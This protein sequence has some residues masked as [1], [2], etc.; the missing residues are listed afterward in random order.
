[1]VFYCIFRIERE[2]SEC[3]P[4]GAGAGPSRPEPE[5][6]GAGRTE[7]AGDGAEPAGA[8]AEPEPEPSRPEPEPSRSRAG[9]SQ[10]RA[11]AEPA[12]SCF[13]NAYETPLTNRSGATGT[14]DDDHDTFSELCTNC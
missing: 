3:H 7:P 13:N 8:G 12:G 2:P 1:M 6:A 4:S 14:Q 9:R 11:G 5:P 10:S